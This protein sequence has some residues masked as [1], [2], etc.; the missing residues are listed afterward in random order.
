VRYRISYQCRF[1]FDDS[2]SEQQVELRL[3]P[4]EDEHQKVHRASLTVDP[5]VETYAY[6]DAFGNDTRCL[7]ILPP[8]AHLDIKLEADVENLL[9]NPFNYIPPTPEEERTDIQSVLKLMPSYWDFVLPSGAMVPSFADLEAPKGWPVYDPNQNLQMS[10]QAALQWITSEFRYEPGSTDVHSPLSD[11]LEKKSGVCQDFAH[12]LCAI[13]R[14]WG[15]P[16][17]YAMGYQFLGEGNHLSANP[18]THAWTEVYLPGAGWR[19]FD[20]TH[21]LMANHHY[22]TVAVGRHSLD[23]APERGSFR[24]ASRGSKPEIQLTIQSQ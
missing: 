13:V 17:R 1:E 4:R 20:A 22:I 6:K 8:H 15:F 12:L 7:S 24:G 11:V 5:A 16:A 3:L 19:G 23:A 2:V 21:S 14:S 9:I 10:V 18:A